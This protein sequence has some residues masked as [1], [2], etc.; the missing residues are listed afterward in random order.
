MSKMGAPSRYLCSGRGLKA[1]VDVASF[2]VTQEPLN[3]ALDLTG[4]ES[5]DCVVAT[6]VAIVDEHSGRERFDRHDLVV[7]VRFGKCTFRILLGQL[8][9]NRPVLLAGWAPAGVVLE[10][11]SW[12]LLATVFE[13]LQRLDL[14]DILRRVCLLVKPTYSI[15][16]G[17][18]KRSFARIACDFD[19]TVSPLE[20]HIGL[21]SV[22]MVGNFLEAFGS[23]CGLHVEILG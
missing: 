19:L 6:N 13:L 15:I 18:Q 23:P 8:F 1:S 20:Q 12:V 17:R 16:A 22:E 10:H 21:G 3:V 5:L 7:D 11:H 9:E 2:D 4:I 14:N